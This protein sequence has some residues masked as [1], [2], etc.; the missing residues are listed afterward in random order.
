MISLMIVFVFW[1]LINNSNHEIWNRFVNGYLPQ[2]FGDPAS[3]FADKWF[4]L[5]PSIKTNMKY[6]ILLNLSEYL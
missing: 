6:M 5:K 2:Y 4:V 1:L 3:N